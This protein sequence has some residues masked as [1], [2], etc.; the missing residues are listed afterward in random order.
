M[1]D[2]LIYKSIEKFLNNFLLLDFPVKYEFTI[3]GKLE[4]TITIHIVFSVDAKKYLFNDEYRSLF[5]GLAEDLY[6]IP[7]YL[8]IPPQKL[9]CRRIFYY[10]NDSFLIKEG[11]ILERMFGKLISGMGIYDKNPIAVDVQKSVDTDIPEFDVYIDFLKVPSSM[12]G[13]E[14]DVIYDLLDNNKFLLPGLNKL[15]DNIHF[16]NLY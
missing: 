12:E 16:E 14:S 10:I 13:M 8:G 6:N 2:N 3:N 1:N 7:N 11:L 4:T 5:D 15:V 9:K